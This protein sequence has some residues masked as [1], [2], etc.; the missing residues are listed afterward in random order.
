MFEYIDDYFK[1]SMTPEGDVRVVD[2]FDL[3]DIKCVT[4]GDGWPV[5]PL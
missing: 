1:P 2:F 5:T 3:P 4:L